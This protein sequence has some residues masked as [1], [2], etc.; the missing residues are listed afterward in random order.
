MSR[1]VI[2]C[3]ILSPSPA[4]L[5]VLQR[6]PISRLVNTD[7]DFVSLGVT[8]VHVLAE[9]GLHGE[10]RVAEVAAHAEG[11]WAHIG[12]AADLVVFA[13]ACFPFLATGVAEFSVAAA[14]RF[15]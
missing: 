14:S 5:T 6:F 9:F 2:V 13:G 15:P 4:I 11:S 3:P 8:C 12:V 10:A 1:R 7:P